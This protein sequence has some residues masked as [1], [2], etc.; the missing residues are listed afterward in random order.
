MSICVL[1]GREHVMK[2]GQNGWRIA[3]VLIIQSVERSVCYCRD[4]LGFQII[5][6]FGSP[7]EM[8]FVGREGVQLMLQDGEG[9]PR[10]GS[11][12]SHKSVAWDAHIWVENVD[13]LYEELGMR[14][15]TILKPPTGR[16][17]AIVRSR[18]PTWMV[19]YF[20]SDS[21]RTRDRVPHSS[22]GRSRD[23]PGMS[24]VRSRRSAH[25]RSRG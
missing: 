4:K 13:A 8:A 17:M 3:P 16:S 5:G 2:Q 24:A 10:P 20:A 12:R 23:E 9:K 14:G 11:N 18:W 19:T 15:A 21:S 6:T 1:Y 22:N 25:D 7:L